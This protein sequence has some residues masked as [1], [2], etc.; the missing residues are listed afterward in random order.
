MNNSKN[1]I[2]LVDPDFDPQ[3]AS[4]CSLL[5]RITGDSFS[6]AIIDTDKK[7]LK[8]VFDIQ[9]FDPT[10]NALR[11]LLKNDSYL[12]LPYLQVK[13]ALFT[14]F[15]VNVPDEVFQT[16]ETE[17]YANFFPAGLT[18]NI[19]SRSSEA[20]NFTSVFHVEKPISKLLEDQFPGLDIF[21]QQTAILTMAKNQP[22]PQQLLLDFTANSFQILVLKEQQLIYVNHFEFDH[23]EEF[24]YY[25]LL[26]I[27]QLQLQA[28]EITLQ[29]SG[30]IHEN[31]A[32]YLC[33]KKYFNQ[34][35]FNTPPANNMDQT[36]LEDMPE[37]YYSSLIALDLC[38]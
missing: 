2:L 29:L 12:Q 9:E 37:H 31:D 28:E 15:Q 25:M 30:I 8:A 19:Y 23:S 20:F 10:S 7:Q 17:T 13:A 38:V 36:I 27:K 6:Y 35:H 1:S 21:D 26:L 33:L 11:K 24:N 34:I 3:T 4:S 22:A 16:Q 32:Q 5:I 14:P 18:G